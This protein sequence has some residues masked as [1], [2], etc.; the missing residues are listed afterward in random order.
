MALLIGPDAP[1]V[2]ERGLSATHMTHAYDFYKPSGLYPAVR[3]AE[4][5]WAG[6][7][8]G[9]GRA[10][11]GQARGRRAV[12]D[13][14]SL[15]AG[16]RVGRQPAS[17]PIPRRLLLWLRMQPLSSRAIMAQP[18][19]RARTHSPPAQRHTLPRLPRSF[20]VDGPLSVYCYLATLDMCYSRYGA[21]FEKRFGR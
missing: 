3:A 10:G 7:R 13:G 16:A 11:K 2:F 12:R 1:L 20:Q 6:S 9:S 5:G 4:W 14:T 17:R 21:K 18:G 19:A 8:L 15:P